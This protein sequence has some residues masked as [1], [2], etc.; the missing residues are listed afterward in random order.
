MATADIRHDATAG[1]QAD[2]TNST[3]APDKSTAELTSD[4]V[5]QISALMHDELALAKAEM[6]EKGK[7]AGLGAGIFGAAGVL[8]LFAVGCLTACVIAAI[9]VATP[10]WV[11]A[12]I[13]GVAYLLAAGI[14]AAMGRAEVARATPPVP[15][16]AV[17]S[18]KEDVEWIK[19]H[20]TS[21]T[22]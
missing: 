4:L 20:A 8:A 5:R 22:R 12:L 15:T 6:T 1:G 14:A 9:A 7:R 11:A 17:E 2:A 18:T 13:V 19:T 16:E 3:A 21:T 10:V